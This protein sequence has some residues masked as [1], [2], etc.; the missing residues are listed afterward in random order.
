MKKM[1][2]T[3]LLVLGVAIQVNEN[4]IVVSYKNGKLTRH[5]KVRKDLSVCLPKVGQKV[6]FYKN[7][8]IV[9]CVDEET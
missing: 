5:S 6:Y 1:I 3:F 8:K 2:I 7:Y 4:D 9:E